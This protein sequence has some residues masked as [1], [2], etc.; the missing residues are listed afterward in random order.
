M[1]KI[2]SGGFRRVTP[3]GL[4][5]E[6]ANEGERGWRAGGGVV[7]VENIVSG[8]EGVDVVEG[9]EGTAFE[10]LGG[11]LPPRTLTVADVARINGTSPD[12]QTSRAPSSLTLH[13]AVV[14]IRSKS[15]G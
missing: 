9:G 1:G 15:T 11:K 13:M 2:S 3:E 5:D 14:G 8:K 12:V 4:K 6:W 10:R 7:V